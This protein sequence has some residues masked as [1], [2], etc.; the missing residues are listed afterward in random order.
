MFNGADQRK[1]RTTHVRFSDECERRLRVE[2][3]K[4][5][6]VEVKKISARQRDAAL[7]SVKNSSPNSNTK[8]SVYMMI[9][10]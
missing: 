3:H 4:G 6:A 8:Y 9:S 10:K 5:A 2:L 7:I 1:V